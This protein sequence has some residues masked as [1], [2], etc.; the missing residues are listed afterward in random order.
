MYCLLCF[1]ILKN[2]SFFKLKWHYN[3]YFSHHHTSLGSTARGATPISLKSGISNRLSPAPREQE[4][5]FHTFRGDSPS[6]PFDSDSDT[7][8]RRMRAQPSPLPMTSSPRHASITSQSD[9]ENDLTP[10]GRPTYPPTM[11]NI[12]ATNPNSSFSGA[13]S[14]DGSLPRQPLRV[15]PL[16]MF[17]PP[18]QRLDSETDQSD[19]GS[20]PSSSLSRR[21]HVPRL[22]YYP[23]IEFSHHPYGGSNRS[24]MGA[25]SNRSSATESDNPYNPS[26][27][28]AD[29][30]RSFSTVDGPP[31]SGGY[32][33]DNSRP[34]S[35]PS[36]PDDT[37]DIRPVSGV[38]M[39]SDF[40]LPP[41]PEVE[42]HEDDD[43][44]LAVH[45][46]LTG[47]S[48]ERDQERA[49]LFHRSRFES[50]A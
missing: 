15:T 7:L 39:D 37:R 21:N 50:S 31:Q 32:N 42:E 10:R 16:P 40:L 28:F 34:P 17:T 24:S 45:G 46:G 23:G 30:N 2:L 20:N 41:Y 35:N 9:T 47:F 27:G 6:Y 44:R 18:H 3:L 49:A 48:P 25:F 19:A 26:S 14:R 22:P 8:T 4:R 11:H 13:D 5:T 1:L 36:Y 33:Y 43:E 12:A 38:S 29:Y